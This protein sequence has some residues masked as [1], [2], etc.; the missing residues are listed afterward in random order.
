M[1]PRALGTGPGA[2]WV[3]APEVLTPPISALLVPLTEPWLL[4]VSGKKG[5]RFRAL[6]RA[7]HRAGRHLPR[8]T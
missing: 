8:V 2:G 7:G 6:A 1:S 3:L 5:Q 4:G